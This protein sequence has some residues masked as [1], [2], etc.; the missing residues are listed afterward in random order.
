MGTARSEFGV[1]N[2]ALAIRSGQASFCDSVLLRPARSFPP[3]YFAGRAGGPMR[4][5]RPVSNATRS[6]VTD[7]GRD[8]A[9]P[10]PAAVQSVKSTM[11]G[12]SIVAAPSHTAPTPPRR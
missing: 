1:G 3:S 8:D 7:V 5:P 9:N 6:L 11:S 10:K 12:D 4:A 2:D